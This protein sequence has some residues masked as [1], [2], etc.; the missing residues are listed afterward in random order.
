MNIDGHEERNDG[1]ADEK[2][3][4]ERVARGEEKGGKAGMS[5]GSRLEREKEN[6]INLAAN[7]KLS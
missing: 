5:G 3:N 6:V 7:N 1:K 4:G 2:K